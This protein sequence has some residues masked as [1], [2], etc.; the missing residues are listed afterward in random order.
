MVDEQTARAWR[1]L[2]PDIT[3]AEVAALEALHRARDWSTTTGA[4]TLAVYRAGVAYAL[5]ADAA[6]VHVQRGRPDGTWGCVCGWV[7]DRPHAEHVAEV[8]GGPEGTPTWPDARPDEHC[9]QCTG[10]YDHVP[11]GPLCL[12]AARMGV[13]RGC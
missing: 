6:E 1:L 12:L 9:P 11:G 5:G 13:G 2:C 7:Q 8:R 3:E 10:P 4:F